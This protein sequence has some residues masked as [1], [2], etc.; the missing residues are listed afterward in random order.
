MV[1]KIER[2][3]EEESGGDVFIAVASRPDLI[4]K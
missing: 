4:P 1:G 2:K 3:K